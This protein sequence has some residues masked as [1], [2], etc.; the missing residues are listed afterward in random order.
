MNNQF[1]AENR[2]ANDNQAFNQ[3]VSGSI[4]QRSNRCMSALCPVAAEFP[5]DR[6]LY[7]HHGQPS[8]RTESAVFGMSNPPPSVWLMVDRIL[9]GFEQPGDLR[10]INA[11]LELHE[12][13]LG[14]VMQDPPSGT[15]DPPFGTNFSYEDFE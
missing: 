13:L 11:F 8:Q 10:A 12:P 9:D 5:H 3:P 4:D 2:D 6:G 7:L 14:T 15:E 1:V